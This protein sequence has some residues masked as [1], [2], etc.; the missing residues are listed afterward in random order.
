M[1]ACWLLGTSVAL[2]LCQTNVS[3]SFS[4]Y[5]WRF[6]RVCVCVRSRAN[7]A[8][9]ALNVFPCG[10]RD[11]LRRHEN[12]TEAHKLVP[13]CAMCY[14][15]LVYIQLHQRQIGRNLLLLPIFGWI[16]IFVT[17]RSFLLHKIVRDN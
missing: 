16:F 10:C 11:M 13:T 6:L 15:F 14:E 2:F 8:A 3:I 17:P 4:R 1:C 9:V 5:F 12:I 7:A